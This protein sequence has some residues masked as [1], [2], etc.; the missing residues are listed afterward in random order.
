MANAKNNA[1]ELQ[2][3]ISDDGKKTGNTSG[4]NG[5]RKKVKP[6]VTIVKSRYMQTPA[7]KPQAQPQPKPATPKKVHHNATFQE[8]SVCADGVLQSTVLSGHA[9]ALRPDIDMSL[10]A[11]TPSSP[12]PRIV[13]PG[14]PK[15]FKESKELLDLQAFFL[16]Y[17]T[18]KMEHNTNMKKKEAE[19]Q[20]VTMLEM[21]RELQVEVQEKKRLY[22]KRERQRQINSL[23]ESQMTDITPLADLSSQFA[24]NYQSLATAVD[25]TLHTLPVKNLHMD[26]D[27]EQFLDKVLSSLERSEE[28]LQQH[29]TASEQESEAVCE[30]LRRIKR[31]GRDLNQQ[32][33]RGG[34]DLKDLSCLVSQ[35]TAEGLLGK[36]NL[37]Q[38]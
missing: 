7:K 4:N 12:L 20:L 37:I 11:T 28:L 15:Q 2:K 27:P 19:K 1:T 6:G 29:T 5:V 24:Q 21:E 26:E 35:L 34:S 32:L 9:N 25:A 30:N 33:V 18:A 16:T 8:T 13:E 36:E 22:H 10:I 3:N 38:P 23:L 31:F 17:L 14:E